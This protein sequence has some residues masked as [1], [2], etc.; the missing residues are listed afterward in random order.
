MDFC[1][2]GN[3]IIC[4]VILFA[5]A[6]TYSILEEIEAFFLFFL[7]TVQHRWYTLIITKLSIIF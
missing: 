5:Y 7:L 6:W 1:Y 4:L 2:T 3:D